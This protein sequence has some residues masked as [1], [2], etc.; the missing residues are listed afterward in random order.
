[1]W[2]K[3]DFVLHIT[4]YTKLRIRTEDVKHFLVKYVKRWF[5]I[6]VI[7]IYIGIVYDIFNIL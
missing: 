4:K 3:I 2:F 7:C 1:M 5:C 6:Q